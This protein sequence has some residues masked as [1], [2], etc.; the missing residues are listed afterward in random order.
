MGAFKEEQHFG[1]GKGSGLTAFIERFNCTLRQ[2]ATR[3][4]RK[5]LSFSN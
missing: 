5:P 1:V 2:R 4:V 3:L